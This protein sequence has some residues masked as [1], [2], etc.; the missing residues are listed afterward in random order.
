MKKVTWGVLSVSKFAMEKAIPAMQRSEL[1]SIEAIASRTLPRAQ[2]A[3]RRLKI[4]RAYGSYEELLA[5]PAIEAI[6]NPL[7]NDL[8]LP[9]TVKAAEAGKH[10]LCE[11]PLTLSADEARAMLA[12]RDR[13]KVLITEA[14]MVRSHPQW[15]KAREV[16]R[17]GR[18]GPLR[19]A[20]GFFSYSNADPKNIRN[21]LSMGG[22]ALM[23]IG[24]YPIVTSRF[25]FESEP[26]RVLSLIERDPKLGID[27]LSSAILDFPAGQAVFTCSTQLVAYQRM[28]FFGTKGRIEVEIPF[29]APPDR[30]CRLFVD[31][32]SS[33]FGEGIEEIAIP[34]CDQYTVQGD[35]FSKMVREKS[36]PEFPLED[37]VK[38]MQV[39]DAL[40]RSAKSGNWEAP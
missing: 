31:D 17:S 16:A 19:A 13:T 29:N 28:N 25:L 27:R 36:R 6:Y 18:I 7:P 12:A 3:A 11:K 21:I 8:H 38:Q 33:L 24:C 35:L 37:A 5:D 26:R 4:P 32:G 2:E 9:W 23:D 1:C 30:P 34:T 15:L 14:F 10:V 40:F 20:Q 22:G 39:I